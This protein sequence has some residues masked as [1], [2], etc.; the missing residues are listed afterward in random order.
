[1]AASVNAGERSVANGPA[2]SGA[3]PEDD[4]F[5]GDDVICA[6]EDC[7]GSAICALAGHA[8]KLVVAAST[9]RNRRTLSFSRTVN[10]ISFPLSV[11]G[12]EIFALQYTDA[13]Y[14]RS[15]G[16]R[17]RQTVRH[18][19]VSSH[20]AILI[21][22]ERHRRPIAQQS[23]GDSAGKKKTLESVDSGQLFHG[24]IAFSD[25]L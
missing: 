8:V 13:S 14:L 18:L 7:G 12:G 15:Q 23:Y 25:L 21:V 19:Q 22:P 1:M 2:S 20:Q 24:L 17:K 9:H 3:S 11:A 16:K 5:S 4:R 6:I 10:A